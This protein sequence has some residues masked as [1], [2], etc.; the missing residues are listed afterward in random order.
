MSAASCDLREFG[1]TDP[2][3]M[4]STSPHILGLSSGNIRGR[5]CDLRALGFADPVK[6]VTSM[7]PILGLYDQHHPPKALRP[8]RAWV[9]R[10]GE[11]GQQQPTIT[12]S[13]EISAGGRFRPGPHC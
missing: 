2:V 11:D 1:F 8:A 7:P 6:M 5:V 9:Y 4:V 3:Q 10:P 13:V 12:E